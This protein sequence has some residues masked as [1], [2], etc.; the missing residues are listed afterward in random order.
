MEVVDSILKGSGEYNIRQ[1][2]M[3]VLEA[4]YGMWGGES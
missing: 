1:N 3:S 2:N 4:F